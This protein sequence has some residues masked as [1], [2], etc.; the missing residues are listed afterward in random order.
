MDYS[1][2]MF[3]ISAPAFLSPRLQGHLRYPHRIREETRLR[4]TRRAR[5]LMKRRAKELVADLP[6][7]TDVRVDVPLAPGHR[8]AYDTICSAMRQKILGL[9]ED[10]DKN[11]FTIFQS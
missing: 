8:K 11:R 9:L 4:A 2:F 10:M 7:K 3:S 5:P 6:E 1:A